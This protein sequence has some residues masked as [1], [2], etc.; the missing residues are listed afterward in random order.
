V[1]DTGDGYLLKTEPAK[2]TD[3]IKNGRLEGTYR[4]DFSRMQTGKP[5]S[6]REGVADFDVDFGGYNYHVKFTPGKDRIDV[7]ATI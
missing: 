7:Q 4:I 3:A 2:I 6:S 1:K 5:S